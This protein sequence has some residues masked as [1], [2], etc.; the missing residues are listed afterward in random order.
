METEY[1]YDFFVIGGGS[2]GMKAATTA[3]KLGA[4]VAVADY[5]VPSP[6]GTTW[7]LGGTCVNVGCI[8]KKLFHYSSLL[9]EARED[10]HATGWG[11][12]TKAS[13]DWKKMTDS[14]TKY[15][16]NLR[17]NAK[18]VLGEMK[19]KYYNML[20]SFVDDHKI[21][22]YDPKKEK[23]ETISAKYILI[24][25]GG[26]PSTL[27]NIPN[28]KELTISSDDIFYLKQNPGKTLV[29]G[30][31]Y[32]ALECA[33]FLTGLG[34]DVTIMVRSVLLRSF[35]QSAATRVGKFMETKGTK[36]IYKA[37][38]E[39]IE[40]LEDGRKRVT[41]KDQDGN[42]QSEIYDSVLSAIGR[43][44]NTPYLNL[45]ACGVKFDAENAKIFTN[46]AE[47]TNVANIYCIGD[48]AFGKPE[49]TPPAVMGGKLLSER[50]FGAGKK[51]MNYK[52]IATTVFTPLEYGVIGYGEDEAIGVFGRSNVTA[53]HSVFKPLEWIYMDERPND[54]CYVKMVCKKDEDEKVIGLHYVGP[55]AGEII[56][57]FSVA[58][59]LGATRED[60]A[61]TVGI[62]PTCAEEV[63]ELTAT[64]DESPVPAGGC[65]GCG[66]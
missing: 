29:I 61:T 3:A 4:R 9:G 35:D 47:Q 54:L 57:G 30:A 59:N 33:G 60:F 15:I 16:R 12:D 20:A 53:Y 25:V 2:G 46:E 32:I 24:A 17:W 6:F 13:H 10:A 23:K 1:D 19:I 52:M 45:E 43:Y 8:P 7:G 63:L 21:E 37:V 39:A 42:L 38:P 51:L 27:P 28:F 49:L 5:V 11:I 31:S 22:L 50:L 44:A 26:R 66:I 48:C 41:Y 18:L 34:N 55:N 65:K 40:K 56:Q 36:F 58:V 14:V 64:T 62:H